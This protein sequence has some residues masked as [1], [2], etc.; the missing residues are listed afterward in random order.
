MMTNDFILPDLGE[1][2]TEAEIV[3]WLVSVGDTIAIDQPVVEVESAKSIVELPSP[4]GGVVKALFGEAGQV[5]HSGQVLLSVTDAGAPPTESTLSGS[6][7]AATPGAAPAPALA[8]SAPA[9][10]ASAASASA[11]SA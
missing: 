9:A 4:F 7:P 8:A 3:S 6:A 5:I 10:S 2:L 11:A 1:G